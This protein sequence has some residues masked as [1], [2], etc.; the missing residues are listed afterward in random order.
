MPGEERTLYLD[1]L[2]LLLVSSV[3]HLSNSSW[4]VEWV[5]C[6]HTIVGV[7]H[8]SHE[9]KTDLCVALRMPWQFRVIV[10]ITGLDEVIEK[11]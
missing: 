4:L 9:N 2:L 5:S 7:K 3:S 10:V 1:L 6:K 8:E 11:V